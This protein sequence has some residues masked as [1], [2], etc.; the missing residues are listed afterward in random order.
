MPPHFLVRYIISVLTIVHILR[1][2]TWKLEL[3]GSQ[4]MT[5]EVLVTLLARTQE[6]PRGASLPIIMV[7]AAS[8]DV[9]RLTVTERTL[10]RWGCKK[11]IKNLISQ[12]NKNFTLYYILRVIKSLSSHNQKPSNQFQNLDLWLIN[13]EF[14]IIAASYQCLFSNSQSKYVKGYSLHQ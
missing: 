11:D 10:I 12:L 9:F 2:H 14:V 6:G 3:D 13:L 7:Q 1:N 8:F 5:D 4:D